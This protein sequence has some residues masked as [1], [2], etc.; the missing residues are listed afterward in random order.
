MKTTHN[1]HDNTIYTCTS[2]HYSNN[3]YMMPV[4]GNCS[5]KIC[6]W[7]GYLWWVFYIQ[8][9]TFDDSQCRSTCY[10]VDT[11]YYDNW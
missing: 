4:Q 10:C 2:V 11:V 6:F 5:S 1:D 3:I 8:N 7:T 9:I